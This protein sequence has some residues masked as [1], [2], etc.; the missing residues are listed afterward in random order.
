M[1]KA[2]VLVTG[3]AGYVGS[4]AALALQE[5]GYPLVLLDNLTRGNHNLVR[6]VIDAP[7][8]VGD[9]A[10]RALT[11]RLFKEY[12]IETVLHFAAFAYVGESVEDPGRYYRNNVA[13]TLALIESMAAAGVRHIVFSSTCATYGMPEVLPITEELPLC[14]INPYG[15]S[16]RMVE[17][18]LE[19]FGAAHGLGYVALRYFNAAGADPEG[20]LGELHHPETHLIP[21][22]LQTALGQC[23]S[24]RIFGEDYDTPDG[25][26]IRDYVHVSDLAAAHVA[27]LEYLRAGGASGAFNLGMGHGYSVREVIETCEAVTARPVRVVAAPR[28]PGDPPRLTA[29][30]GKAKRVLGWTPQFVELDTVV[31]HAWRFLAAR[32]G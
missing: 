17:Q 13:G 25:T 18:I 14:P 23:E 32:Q 8:I 10:D 27:A 24:V 3:G 15:R 4:H 29:D 5:A 22:V 31:R 6:G 28:R 2:T 9:I 11:A 12:P 26:C 16:K 21:L 7:L 20:R 19:D 30:C 1:G